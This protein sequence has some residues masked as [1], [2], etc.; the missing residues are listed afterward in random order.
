MKLL[1][2]EDNPKLSASLKEGLEREGY[3]VDP[4]FDGPSAERRLEAHPATYDAVVL[5]VM[6]PG[7]DGIAVCKR[8]REE[9]VLAPVLLLTALD[10]T[11]DRVRGLDAGADDYLVKPFA[12]DELLAR[13]RALLRR[14]AAVQP[15]LASVGPLAIDRRNRDARLSG[16]PLPLTVREFAVL[17]Y[18]ARHPGQTLTREQILDKVWRHE[19]EGFSNVVDVHVKNLRKKLGTYGSHLKTVRGVGYRLS[20]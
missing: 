16:R 14:P 17:E 11:G 19:F 5:D 10:A 1:L 15:D 2:V 13:L 4:L 12:F 8:L 7:K 6:L 9:N 20:V 18:L 3:V